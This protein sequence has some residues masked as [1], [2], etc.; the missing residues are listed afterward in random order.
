MDN[1]TRLDRVSIFNDKLSF[2]IPHEWIEILD[3]DD[4]L[5]QYPEAESGWLRVS[6]LTVKTGEEAPAP[7]LRKIFDSKENVIVEHQTGN[8][9]S[10]YEKDSENDGVRIHL[11]YW[12]VANVVP[13]N[14]VREAIFS[15]TVLIERII[16][17]DTKR[18][19]K[20]VGQLVSQADFCPSG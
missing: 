2:L 5:Y 4:Y 14:L 17:E 7:R 11:W 12:M 9:V 20:L 18:M 8:L 10:T 3:D 6:L 19:V 13:P 1:I 15:Y 16:E